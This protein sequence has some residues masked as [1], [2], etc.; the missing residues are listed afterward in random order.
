MSTPNRVVHRFW[1]GAGSASPA[2]VAIRTP[3]MVS[4]GRSAAS[5]A[6]KKAGAA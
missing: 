1:S 2:D 5:M 3:A 6:A 4:A